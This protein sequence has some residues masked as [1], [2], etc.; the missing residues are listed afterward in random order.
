VFGKEV[1]FI[2][3]ERDCTISFAATCHC[4]PLRPWRQTSSQCPNWAER[5]TKIDIEHVTRKERE[6]ERRPRSVGGSGSWHGRRFVCGDPDI[7]LYCAPFHGALDVLSGMPLRGREEDERLRVSDNQ[8]EELSWTF[9]GSS[10]YRMAKLPSA[11][12]MWTTWV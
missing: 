12:K 5:H 3:H 1:R 6:A 8:I 2:H 9:E 4:L 10:Q 11:G 7:R